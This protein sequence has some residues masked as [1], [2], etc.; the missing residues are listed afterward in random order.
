VRKTR[1]ALVNFFQ[2]QACERGGE[3]WDPDIDI[4]ESRGDRPDPFSKQEREL[5]RTTALEYDSIP[6][7]NDLSPEE[8]SRWKAHLAQKLGKP[9]AEVTP[10]DW[11][12]ASQSWKVPSLI[13]AALDAGLRPIEIERS[14]V[15]WLR[16]DKQVLHIPKEHAAKNRDHWEPALTDRTCGA[17]ERWLRERETRRKYDDS[18]AIW[19]TRQGNP[20]SSSSLN[21]LLERLLEEMDIQTENRR[22]CW[23]SIRHSTGMYLATDGDLSEAREQL[24]HSNPETTMQYA[25]PPPEE[26]RDTLDGI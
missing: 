13:M 10:D 2:W 8:R 1:D 25:R 26:R 12:R 17:L 15:D 4:D 20:Y 11:Q 3:P 21:Y 5:L 19:L 6:G 23:Y 16:L 14:T 7:Y 9:K 22:L 24:R 18:D